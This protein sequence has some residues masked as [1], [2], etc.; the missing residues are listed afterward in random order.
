MPSRI[1]CGR[2]SSVASV[3]LIAAASDSLPAL[4]SQLANAHSVVV[5]NTP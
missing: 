2:I 4:G 3:H 1:D 5:T